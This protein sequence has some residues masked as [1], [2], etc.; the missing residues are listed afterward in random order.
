MDKEYG[1]RLQAI[2]IS[3][4]DNIQMIKNQGMESLLGQLATSIREIMKMI[5]GMVMVRCTGV[6]VVSTR[7]NGEKAFSMVREKFMCLARDIRR[8]FLRIMC[9]WWFRNNLKLLTI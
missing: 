3:M 4:K 6:M 1:R 8:V 7:E 9:W 2:L 5:I